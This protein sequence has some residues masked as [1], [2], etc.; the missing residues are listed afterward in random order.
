MKKQ[1][2]FEKKLKQIKKVFDIDFLLNQS[3]KNREIGRYYKFNKLS[4][5][6]FHSYK[7]YL[8]M[9]ISR[10]G[11]YKKED[12]EEMVRE[13][14]FLIKKSNSKRVLE[15][16]SGRGANTYYLAKRNPNIEFI[17]TDFFQKPLRKYELK[18]IKFFRGDYHKLDFIDDNSIDIAFIIEAFCYSKNKGIFLKE[19]EKKLKKEGYLIIFDGYIGKDETNLTKEEKLAIVLVAKS[20]ALDKFDKVE[21]L[22]KFIKEQNK[23]KILEKENLSEYIFPTLKRFERMAKFY[24]KFPILAKMIN[25]IFPIEFTQNVIAGYLMPDLIKSRAGV[26][27]KHILKKS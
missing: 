1:S 11:K 22:E 25:R 18:N 13:I 21:N 16:A 17:A 27:Y 3:Q 26:Y 5:R 4:Y 19:I 20:M 7:A 14:N 12:L 6:L 10:N 9:G 15:L 23:F 24:F 2:Q 8:H